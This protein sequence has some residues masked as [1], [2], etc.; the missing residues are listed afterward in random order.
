MSNKNKKASPL[1]QQYSS[2]EDY[3]FNQYLEETGINPFASNSAGGA[4]IRQGFY[5]WMQGG[6]GGPQADVD[7]NSIDQTVE[8][9]MGGNKDYLMQTG[10]ASNQQQIQDALDNQAT[11]QGVANDSYDAFANTQFTN[12]FGNLENPYAGIQTDFQNLGAGYGNVT[13]GMRPA[14]AG[15]SSVMENMQLTINRDGSKSYVARPKYQNVYADAQN[16]YAGAQNVAAGAR[17]VSAGMGNYAAGAQNVYAGAQNTFAGMSNAYEGLQNQFAGMENAYA[18]LENQYEGMENRYED[19]T[20]DMRAA[21]FQAQQGQQQRANIMQGLRGAAG[22]SGIAG[23]A[24]AMAGQGQLQAQQQAA[25]IGQQERQNKMMAAQEGSRIDMTQR[26]EASRLASQAA[27]GTMQNQAMMRQGAAQLQ[28]QQAQA[29]MANQMASRQG[30]MQAQQMRMG[31]AAQ[32][33]QLQMQGAAAL[34][35]MQFQGASEQ[36]RLQLAGAAEQQQMI[37]GG[38]A[39]QQQMILGGAQTLQNQTI[40]A[41]Q[42][43]Q[44]QQIAAASQLQGIEAQSA[45]QN[46]QMQFQ[47]ATNAQQNSIAQNNLIAQGAWAA[48]MAAAQGAMDVQGMEFG[49]QSTL[50]GID[51]A[52]LAGANEAVQMGYSNELAYAGLEQGVNMQNSA[53]QQSGQNS[54]MGLIGMALPY[55]FPPASDKRLKKNISKIGESPSGLNVYSFEYKD[56]KYGKGLFQGVMSDE[57]P[58]EAVMRMDNGYD[59]VDYSK[60]DVEFK[61]I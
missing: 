6:G 49:Q 13:D 57:I 15:M 30:E 11:M 20:V 44:S 50:L 23:L 4:S 38:A 8:Q 39:Q 43:L 54:F 36:Q 42:T 28:S 60:L 41:A 53:N 10:A 17:D 27:A 14:T 45:M 29:T 21:D 3:M 9:G 46:Q 61:Q 35:G 22:S 7:G 40:G 26:G 19:M 16:V 25:G 12:F 1:K 51:Y 56:S 24:Q 18:G 55:I 47:G 59:A 48:D 31:G 58:Q 37:L 32:Q 33:Q 2:Y 5:E 52:N 34:Q